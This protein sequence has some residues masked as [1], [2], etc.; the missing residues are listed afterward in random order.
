MYN[1]EGKAIFRGVK[2]IATAYPESNVALAKDEIP[3]ML[4]VH[5]I[6]PFESHH[7]RMSVIS[8]SGTSHDSRTIIDSISTLLPCTAIKRH[9][10]RQ[11]EETF[12]LVQY[13]SGL[14]T[15]QGS[16]STW[17]E[18]LRHFWACVTLTLYLATTWRCWRSIPDKATR[19]SC[20]GP[21]WKEGLLYYLQE[22][23]YMNFCNS[24][25]LNA[26]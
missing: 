17:K 20:R 3:V 9:W 7:K 21:I 11:Q 5:K 18:P 6:F 13:L 14:C 8:R 10:L 1:T 24:T 2:C 22:F 26:S 4:E 16:S 15:G 25:D 19:Y 12:S 23:K